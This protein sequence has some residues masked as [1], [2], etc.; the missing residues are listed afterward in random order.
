MIKTKISTLKKALQMF[1]SYHAG[2]CMYKKKENTRHMGS[3]YLQ[4]LNTG[5]NPLQWLLRSS[6]SP[7]QHLRTD[8]VIPGWSKDF[9]FINLSGTRSSISLLNSAFLQTICNMNKNTSHKSNNRGIQV[10]FWW[11]YVLIKKTQW[12]WFYIFRLIF[13]GI[14]TSSS[15][16]KRVQ[17]IEPVFGC[18]ASCL[19][20]KSNGFD[21]AAVEIAFPLSVGPTA[22]HVCVVFS[23]LLCLLLR[24]S[25]L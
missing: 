16:L 7:S 15:V 8:N 17:N 9:N 2:T 21:A 3:L 19:F 24:C 12:K 22:F 23:S 20:N 14:F 11:Q 25:S 4:Q 10:V 6:I 1:L 13:D 18:G 5:S